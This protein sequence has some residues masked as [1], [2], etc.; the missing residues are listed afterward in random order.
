M[1]HFD[2]L[3]RR[4]IIEQGQRIGSFTLQSVVLEYATTRLIAEA[5]HEIEQGQRVCLIEMGV[6][7]V[8]AQTKE[9]V[10]KAQEHLL[11]VPLLTLLQSTSLGHIDV[12]GRLLSLLDLYAGPWDEKFQ[13]YGPANLV[14]LLAVLRGDLR[15]L[16]PLA[17]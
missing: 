7:R 2:R 6:G 14:A 17:S 13:G 3:Q 15:G 11:V 10:R 4:S 8:L 12:E 16:N 9:Y 1:K 5:A